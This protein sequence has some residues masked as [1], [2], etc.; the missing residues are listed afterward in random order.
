MLR[1]ADPRLTN[2]RAI[3]DRPT[4]RRLEPPRPLTCAK[5]GEPG[6]SGRAPLE[7]VIE[8]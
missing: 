4:A 2:G 6:K 5:S 7:P 3:P 8:T 1:E